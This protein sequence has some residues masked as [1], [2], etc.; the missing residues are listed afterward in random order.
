[1]YFPVGKTL[2]YSHGLILYTPFYGIGRL[3]LHPFQAYNVTLLVV[4]E[5]GILCLYLLLRKHFRVSFIEALLLSAFFFSSRNVINGGTGVWS[6]RHPYFSSGDSFHLVYLDARRRPGSTRARGLAG[7]LTTLLFT[8][9]FY[10]AQFA[11]LFVVLLVPAVALGE[12]TTPM[13]VRI[14][15]LW[16]ADERP[17]ARGLL[18]VIVLTTIWTGYVLLYGGGTVHVFGQR[19]TS[20]DWWRPALV[21]LAGLAVFAGMRGG[22]GIRPKL[23]AV[24]PWLLAFGFGAVVGHFLSSPLPSSTRSRS[25]NIWSLYG[26][27]ALS[28]P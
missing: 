2:G 14:A 28:S 16:N 6:Q 13:S 4:I 17:A 3:F 1:M 12:S 5:T 7:L 24:R 21:A 22:I 23:W 26:I 27:D 11:L 25:E 10:T 9:D 18:V 15:G 8:Q 19:I 20:H